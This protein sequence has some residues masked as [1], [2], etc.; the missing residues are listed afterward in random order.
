VLRLAASERR[1]PGSVR[2]QGLARH[3]RP[4]PA[5]SSCDSIHDEHADGQA[6]P[7]K[8]IEDGRRVDQARARHA[9]ARDHDEGDHEGKPEGEPDR[10]DTTSAT[11]ERF[12]ERAH[13]RPGDRRPGVSSG[14]RR[15][16]A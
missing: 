3:R 15:P 16:S 2:R 10:C 6:H 1:R 12:R 9:E 13:H 11:R 7:V 14:R 8:D 5:R 4:R